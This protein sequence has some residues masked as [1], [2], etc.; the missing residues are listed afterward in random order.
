MK[1]CMEQLEGMLGDAPALRPEVL[2]WISGENLWNI[3]VPEEFGGL[4]MAFAAGLS[5]LQA[6]ARLDGSLGWTVTLCS[7][8]NYFIG[9]LKPQTAREIFGGPA[10]LGGSGGLFGTAQKIDGRYKLNGKWRYAT[11]APYLTH[12]TLNAKII[13]DGKEL[14]HDDG[15]PEFLSFVVAASDVEIIEDWNTMG[16]KASATHSFKVENVMVDEAY[17]FVYNRFCLNQSIFK[18]PFS[19]FADL[20]LWVNYIGMV[21]HFIEEVN[22]T[23]KAET[24]ALDEVIAAANKK[25]YELAKE[26]EIITAQERQFTEKFNMEA[27]Q[28]A[29]ASVRELSKTII[30]L[31]PSL[32]V[33]AS[34][35]GQVLNQIFRDYFTATQHHNFTR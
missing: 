24:T 33:N 12:F 11:G 5:K 18:I 35:D 21:E 16:L 8:A 17:S 14:S 31:Y 32:G 6:L 10:I 13:E 27:H 25:V 23:D 20:T 1:K 29:A 30:A 2:N 4:E 22:A 7:G 19:V 9:N 34:R 28:W 3:W 26:I 15:S